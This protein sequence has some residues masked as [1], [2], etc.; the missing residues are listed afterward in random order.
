MQLLD[1]FYWQEQEA[2]VEHLRKKLHIEKGE[3]KYE[4]SQTTH[5]NFFQEFEQEVIINLKNESLNMMI[6]IPCKLQNVNLIG[7][8]KRF[9]KSNIILVRRT[10][11]YPVLISMARCRPK[12]IEYF[13]ETMAF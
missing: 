2:K 12:L 8:G 10:L 6:K 9:S 11:N 5:F 1:F 7:R 3:E 4:S 13:S